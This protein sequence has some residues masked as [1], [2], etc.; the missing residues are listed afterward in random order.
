M[1]K[2]AGAAVPLVLP[3]PGPSTVL[4]NPV[5]RELIRLKSGAPVVGSNKPDLPNADTNDPSPLSAAATAGACAAVLGSPLVRV[6]ISWPAEVSNVPTA[7]KSRGGAVGAD[8]PF[9]DVNAVTNGATLLIIRA[10]LYSTSLA[11]VPLP[12][13]F[14]PPGDV[15]D[16]IPVKKGLTAVSRGAKAAIAPLFSAAKPDELLLLL[17]FAVAGL[18]LVVVSVALKA[19]VNDPSM[20]LAADEFVHPDALAALLLNTLSK[21]PMRLI[22]SVAVDEGATVDVV[23]GVVVVLAAAIPLIRFVT[24]FWI[25]GS[26][27]PLLI[28]LR[29]FCMASGLDGLVAASR[30]GAA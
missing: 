2:L 17:V 18:R 29:M 26:A 8:V 9:E 1:L 4:V 7:F 6:G 12:A 15:P 27:A 20:P 16:R 14:A 28:M 3:A 22:T 30:E 13:A 21:G 19:A 11:A 10:S 5:T 24:A 25:L 23:P